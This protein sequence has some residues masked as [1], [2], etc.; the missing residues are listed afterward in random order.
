MTKQRTTEL[1]VGVGVGLGLLLLII[2]IML[3]GGDKSF[4]SSTYILKVPFDK[5]DGLA[6]GSLVRLSGFEIGNISDIG[7]SE[8]DSKLLVSLKILKKY[9]DRITTN[10]LAG[11]RTQGALG[12]KYVYISPG[13]SGGTVL[14]NEDFIQVEQSADIFTTLS[15]RGDEIAK[16]FD[17]LNELS[18]FAK[19]LN[20]DGRSDKLMEN[21]VSASGHMNQAMEKFNLAISDLRGVDQKNLKNASKD[22]A[23]ILEKLDNG[24]G[25]LGALINDPTISEKLKAILGG[26]KRSDYMKSLIQ[27]TIQDGKN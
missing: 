12:D 2:T 15:Q 3:L 21:M 23:S 5:V 1:K 24:S 7:F 10:S 20:K 11:L 4:L 16:V 13:Q 25:T 19:T 6:P 9:Q 18:I 26:G 27:K 22:L 17:I 8:K 14:K